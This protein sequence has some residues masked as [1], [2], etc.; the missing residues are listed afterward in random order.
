[1]RRVATNFHS[2]HRLAAMTFGVAALALSMCAGAVAQ[3]PPKPVAP[4]L[5]VAIGDSITFGYGLH[6]PGRDAFPYIVARRLGVQVL[7]LGIPGADARD[8]LKLESPRVPRTATIITIFVGTNDA[9]RIRR[10]TFTTAQFQAKYRSLISEAQAAAPLASIY[11]LTPETAFSHRFGVITFIRSQASPSARLIDLDRDERLHMRANYQPD[12]I[13]PNVAG[14]QQIATDV[15]EGIA[16]YAAS[17][18][19][20]KGR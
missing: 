2:A 4:G 7:D 8:A 10:G 13:H 17:H 15:L 1:M 3:S 20:K 9:D 19:S 11:I 16:R 14:Q 5:Y 6:A 12:F 18:P